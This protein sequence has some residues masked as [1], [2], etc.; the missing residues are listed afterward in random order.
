MY[1][2]FG[3]KRISVN[4]VDRPQLEHEVLVRLKEVSGFALATINLDHLVKLEQDAD[5]LAA[6]AAHDLVVADGHPVVWLSRVAGRPVQLMPG[7]DMVVPLCRLAVQAGVSVALVGSTREALSD[8]R[9]TLLAEVP[10]L[11]VTWCHA[12]SGVFDPDSE[13]AA[14][15][16]S[17][18]NRKKVGLCFLALGAPKQERL[19]AR[20]RGLAPGV[21]FASVGA[22]LDFLGGHQRRAPAWVRRLALEWLWRA[23]SSPSRMIPR[24][25]KCLAILPK[26]T[27]M[28]LRLRQ[29]GNSPS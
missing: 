4:I 19:A 12:P 29:G 10:G 27:L 25:L 3:D 24:Y 14:E 11:D 8:A 2:E 16:L 5:F 28:A 26:H 17:A 21:G 7:S 9:Q 1:F 22:G 23:L 13:E 15:I 18:L 20:G 6:Y